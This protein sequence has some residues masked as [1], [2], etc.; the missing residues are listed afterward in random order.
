RPRARFSAAVVA[1]PG[2]RIVAGVR[3]RPGKDRDEDVLEDIVPEQ[4]RKQTGYDHFAW[5][6][7]VFRK[8]GGEYHPHTPR[9]PG[10]SAR[11]S[12]PFG[13]RARPGEARLTGTRGP[14]RHGAGARPALAGLLLATV[15]IERLS[16][17]FARVGVLDGGMVVLV[18]GRR[19]CLRHPSGKHEPK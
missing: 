13:P 12:A 10:P 2:G 1:D 3:T 9:P 5:R 17:W 6:G 16:E 18:D 11:S 7:W 4:V 8:T 15:K 14:S 19:H